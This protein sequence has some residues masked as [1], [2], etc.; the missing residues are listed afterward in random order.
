MA[1]P[2]QDTVV[3]YPAGSILAQTQVLHSQRDSSGRA[4]VLLDRTPVHPVDAGWPDQGADRAVL[5]YAGQELPVVDCLVAATDGSALY[6][7]QDIPVSKGTQGW[8]F[9]VAHVIDGSTPP[10]GAAVT[11]EVDAAYR[12]AVSAGHTGCHLASLAL[13]EAVADCWKKEVRP[14]ALGS[15]DFDGLAI[16]RTRIHEFGSLDTYRLGKSLRRKGF[17]VTDLAPQDVATDV[18]SILATWV[19]SGA[20]VDIKRDGERL[21]DRRYWSCSL[22][23]GEARIPCGGT[24]ARS[25]AEFSNVVVSLQL[26][27]V[28]GTP[29]LR[30]ETTVAA[31]VDN[32]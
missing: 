13:N 5:R 9:V 14:D 23:A 17:T 24:H 8:A 25:L 31:A 26:E 28:A 7:G 19:A 4:Y 3:T 27:D 2:L 10:E 1:L 32:P 18:N 22:P 21:T 12:R 30:M 6:V 16:D 15:P 11:V 29:V 20:P